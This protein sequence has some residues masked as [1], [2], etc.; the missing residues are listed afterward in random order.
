M[1]LAAVQPADP[2]L[3]VAELVCQTALLVAGV[4]AFIWQWRENRQ[5]NPL[6]V[7]AW[8]T[9]WLHFGLWLWIFSCAAVL[10]TNIYD[11]FAGPLSGNNDDPLSLIRR[12]GVMHGAILATQIAYLR[13]KRPWS[14]G[15]V[16]SQWLSSIEILAKGV[17]TWL[18][19]IPVVGLTSLIWEFVLEG[20]QSLSPNVSTPEQTTVQMVQQ[21]TDHRQQALMKLFTVVIAPINEE[22]FFRAG[23]YRFFKGQIKPMWAMILANL[24]FAAIHF[25]LLTAVPLFVLGIILTRVYV[26]T[27]NIAVSMVLHALF[28]L[29]T[30]AFLL[31]FP[32][33]G[34]YPTEV[35]CIPLHKI[36]RNQSPI[37]AKRR[38]CARFEAGWVTYL[39]RRRGALAMIVRFSIW[40]RRGDP[41]ED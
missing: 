26:R 9:S 12:A 22:L 41:R 6:G 15:P 39:L 38:C 1:I 14:P 28:N 4:A 5:T 30:V 11:L 24:L 17:P 2:P 37:W 13:I 16:N 33:L 27:G 32:D 19:A 29:T 23:L 18:A 40:A 7:P 35:R 10:A 25:N 21:L 36:R 34:A 8:N 3:N 31:I 20:I